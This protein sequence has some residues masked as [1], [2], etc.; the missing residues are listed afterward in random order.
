VIFSV[1]LT[2]SLLAFVVYA[3]LQ[4]RDY[5]VVAR[6]IPFVCGAGIYFTWSPERTSQLA[7]FVGIGR[8]TDLI[9]YIW[10]L[11]SGLLILVLHL[12][13]LSYGRRLTELARAIAIANAEAPRED[14][15]KRD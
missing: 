15:P 6:T 4:H 11:L 8:G 13:L 3:L 12:K 1:V 10:V 14:S 5:P 2:V 9:L 7:H